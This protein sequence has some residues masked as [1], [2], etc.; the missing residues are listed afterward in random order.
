VAGRPPFSRQRD[1]R[2]KYD[3]WA[4]LRAAEFAA[5]EY[6]WGPD[7]IDDVLTDEQLVAYLDAAQ[8]RA[9]NEARNR[10]T[11]AVE[12]AR[13][14][15]IF[16]HDQKQYDRWRSDVERQTGQR[17]DGKSLAQLARDLGQVVESVGGLE[18]VRGEFEFRN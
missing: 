4:V 13:L 14:G 3:P 2:G 7:Y 15:W 8:E 6:G 17:A 18:V 10:R 9:V 5:T 1:R 12:S 11:E 16:A